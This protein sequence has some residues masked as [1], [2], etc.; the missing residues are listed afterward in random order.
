[1]QIQ[2][3]KKLRKCRIAYKIYTELTTRKAALL[4]DHDGDVINEIYDSW[5]ALFKVIREELKNLSGKS[6]LESDS[7]E[8]VEMVTQ[9]LNKGLRPL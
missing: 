1:M 6:I 3:T 2:H 7:K 5:Y 8:L 9:I 4:I